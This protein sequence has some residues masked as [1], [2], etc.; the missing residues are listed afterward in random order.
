VS[1]SV[2]NL[3]FHLFLFSYR[4][5]LSDPTEDVRVATETLLADFLRE[6][7]DVSIVRRQLDEQAKA[8][9][10]AE[11]MRHVDMQENLP[12]LTL[13]SSERAVFLNDNDQQTSPDSA[14]AVKDDYASTNV[15]DRDTGGEVQANA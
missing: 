1:P 9:T 13:E 5:Y 2:T 4:K 3:R 12:D 7:R 11:S 6:I 15:D 8:R 10:P 14:S